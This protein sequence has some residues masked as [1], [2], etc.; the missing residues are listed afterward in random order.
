MLPALMTSCA[1]NDRK[2]LLSVKQLKIWELTCGAIIQPELPN[3][4]ADRLFCSSGV[5]RPKSPV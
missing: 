1:N 2:S 4:K 3:W 5:K